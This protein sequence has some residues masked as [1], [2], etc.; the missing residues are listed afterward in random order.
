[1]ADDDS[2]AQADDD[3]SSDGGAASR[4]GLDL[5]KLIFSDESS[6]GGTTLTDP[7]GTAGGGRRAKETAQVI[8]TVVLAVALVVALAG[9]VYI[10]VTPQQATDP[11]TEFYILGA[12]G[13]ASDYPT[14]LTPGE[15]ASV[16][17]GITNH[18]QQETTYTVLVTAGDQLLTSRSVTIGNQETWEEP[19]RYSLNQTGNVRVRFLLYQGSNPTSGAE[20]YR[21]AWLWTNVTQ[22]N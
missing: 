10:A 13:N 14:R 12:E 2:S 21:S 5:D 20:P 11:Y 9:V 1:M 17:L 15:E 16:T 3:G 8:L 19:V 6:D 4:V 22:E 18:E 7:G